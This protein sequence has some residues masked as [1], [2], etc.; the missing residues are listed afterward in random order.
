MLGTVIRRRLIRG[1]VIGGEN[2]ATVGE[3][4]P[5]TEGATPVAGG[6]GSATPPVTGAPGV[7]W[8]DWSGR[9]DER[10]RVRPIISIL[11]G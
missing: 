6:G 5:V 9:M 4:A 11:Q 10:M 7:A 3:G 2:G 8:A 1:Y